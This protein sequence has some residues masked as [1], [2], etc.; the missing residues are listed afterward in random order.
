MSSRSLA[1]A[2]PSV[3]RLSA[4]FRLRGAEGGHA[5]CP[6]TPHRPLATR[7]PT[8]SSC[9]PTAEDSNWAMASLPLAFTV[10]RY[11]STMSLRRSRG[12]WGSSCCQK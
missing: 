11:T 6:G 10:S 9:L 4:S 3:S 5:R 2:A 7:L 12:A 8:Y 1:A